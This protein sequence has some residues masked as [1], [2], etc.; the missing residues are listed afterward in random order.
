MQATTGK[1][2]GEAERILGYLARK[3]GQATR[4]RVL[5][6]KAVKGNADRYDAILEQLIKEG[7]VVCETQTEK[8]NWIYRVSCLDTSVP[9]Q[10]A[11]PAG[12]DSIIEIEQPVGN[13]SPY[14][15]KNITTELMEITP[16]I[17]QDMLRYNGAGNRPI[18]TSHVAD[19][20]R[21]IK[22]GEWRIT[23]NAIAFDVEGQVIDGQ[24]RLLAVVRCQ[25]SIMSQVT[26]G[27][28]RG[29]F[30]V[31]DRGKAR[32]AG[33]I[34]GLLGMRYYKNVGT[35]IKLLYQFERGTIGKSN[36]GPSN[37]EVVL[38]LVANRD[39]EFSAPVGRSVS[40]LLSCGI[41]TFCHYIFAKKSKEDADNFFESLRTGDKSSAYDPVWVLRERLLREKA[42]RAKLPRHEIVA[43]V[44]VAWNHYRADRQ[45]KCLRWSQS[46]KSFPE[47]I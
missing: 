33:D 25:I 21:A 34:A 46:S 42:N 47:P 44:I 22:Q 31:I 38:L 10:R 29:T 11:K 26:F 43:W 28:P 24:H 36:A 35:A 40:F 16:D 15:R 4:N 17:A 18:R 12:L 39:I 5:A 14:A 41:A 20:A 6:S 3:G 19:L 23:N 45:I 13:R 37:T 2:N 27:L 30:M 32:D 8:K 9:E 1:S 7:K